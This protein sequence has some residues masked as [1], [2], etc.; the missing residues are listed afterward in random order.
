MN[1]IQEICRKID[2]K[3]YI[4]RKNNLIIELNDA[5]YK[6]DIYS[7]VVNHESGRYSELIH[8]NLIKEVFNKKKLMEV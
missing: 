5:S 1:L 6:I 2:V 3:N 7:G 4:L 8:G